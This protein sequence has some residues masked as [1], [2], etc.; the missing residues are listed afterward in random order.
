MKGKISNTNITKEQTREFGM[1]AVLVISFIA[2]YFG[3][4]SLTGI[5][6]ILALLTLL[7]PGIFYPF[8]F[9]WFAFSKIMAKIS[10]KI[11]LGIIFF[12]IVIPVAWIRK[13]MRYDG[14][15]KNHFKKGSASIMTN[16]DHTYSES[17]LAHTF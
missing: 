11:I 10:T 1:L 14:L 8:A 13:L 17:D 7:I 12:V 2:F 6:C 15:K 3:K 4:N 9:C 16:R 5:I